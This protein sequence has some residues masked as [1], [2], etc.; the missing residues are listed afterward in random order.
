MIRCRL[1]FFWLLLALPSTAQAQA[2]N[3]NAGVDLGARAFI[4]CRSCHNLKPHEP[5]EVGPNLAG[6][7]GTRIATHRPNFK[8]S[9][10]AKASPLVWTDANLDR[11]LEDPSATV[12]GTNMAF[13]GIKKA[14][15]R[16]AL[17]E[18]LKRETR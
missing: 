13:V 8:Y 11:W 4:Q 18:Y 9:E 12:P 2:K 16:A 7:L 6:F 10:A 17:I 3:Q 15:T 5:D 1:A 14:E